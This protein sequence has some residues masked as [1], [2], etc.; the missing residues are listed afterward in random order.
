MLKGEDA[1]KCVFHIAR[2]S[3]RRLGGFDADR[4][5]V[6]QPAA[7]TIRSSCDDDDRGDF[8]LNDTTILNFKMRLAVWHL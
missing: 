4:R 7:V 8:Q 6:R 3:D 1:P 5:K 2:G